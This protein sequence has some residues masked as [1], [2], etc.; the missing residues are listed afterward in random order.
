MD[1]IEKYIKDH[2]SS[3]DDQHPSETLWL[4]INSQLDRGGKEI[5]LFRHA[6]KA[7]AIILFTMVIWLLFDRQN[8]I[9]QLNL[10]QIETTGGIAFNEVENYY[11]AQIELK[12]REISRFIAVNP[13]VD[14]QLMIDINK[15][16]STYQQL[17][18][19]LIQGPNEKIID[20]MVINLQIRIELLNQQLS[21]LDRIKQLKDQ[22][23]GTKNI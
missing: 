20:A 14:E 12:Q 2:R 17:K 18:K 6:W 21:V 22:N 16:D 5:P 1:K 3:F 4:R 19:K 13:E 8:Q 15:L 7:A 23:N 9:E 10:S 11:V